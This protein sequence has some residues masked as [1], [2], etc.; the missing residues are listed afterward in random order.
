MVRWLQIFTVICML[1]VLII[2]FVLLGC[3]PA[4]VNIGPNVRWPAQPRE[5]C[6]RGM[7]MTSRGNGTA[8][9]PLDQLLPNSCKPYRCPDTGHRFWECIPTPATHG[10]TP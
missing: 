4:R 7:G 8:C 6:P 10:G 5:D 3:T 2:V 9:W 1:G